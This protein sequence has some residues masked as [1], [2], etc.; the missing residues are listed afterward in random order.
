M[1]PD[2]PHRAVAVGGSASKPARPAKE[3]A[4][5]SINALFDNLIQIGTGIVFS[6]AVF[7]VIVGAFQYL[8]AAGSPH[9]M[10]RGK[11]TMVNALFGMVVVISARV[12]ANM[13]R[14]SL[15]GAGA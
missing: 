10:E 14:T 7:F 1:R 8:T 13:I 12:I 6:V 11:S 2:A 3:T 5:E 9:Q 15:T 4:V